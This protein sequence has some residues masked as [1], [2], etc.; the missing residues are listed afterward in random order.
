MKNDVGEQCSVSEMMSV[1]RNRHSDSCYKGNDIE[2][3]ECGIQT[4]PIS[5]LISLHI[6]SCHFTSKT[7][8]LK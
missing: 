2:V 7:Q 4:T 6:T 5:R 1:I 8:M 3:F